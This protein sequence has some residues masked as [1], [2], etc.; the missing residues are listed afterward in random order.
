MMSKLIADYVG[1]HP[2]QTLIYGFICYA[3]IMLGLA[4][5]STDE[6]KKGGR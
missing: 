1:A 4:L 5:A 3:L 6:P 2:Y